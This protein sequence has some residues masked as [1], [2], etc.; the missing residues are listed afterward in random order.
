MVVVVAYCGR[1]ALRSDSGVPR[2]YRN[3]GGWFALPRK[4]GGVGWG[5]VELSWVELS[6]SGGAGERVLGGEGTLLS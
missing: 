3:K 2:E 4:R 6:G 1:R 5:G